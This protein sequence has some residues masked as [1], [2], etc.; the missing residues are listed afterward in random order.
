MDKMRDEQNKQIVYGKIEQGSLKIGD[1]VVIAPSD[2]PCQVDVIE[3][4]TGNQVRYA[5]PGEN[6]NLK[7]LHANA[8][9]INKGDMLCH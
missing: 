1:R 3:D 7:L 5:R 8:D 4:G 6:V 2:I 9:N